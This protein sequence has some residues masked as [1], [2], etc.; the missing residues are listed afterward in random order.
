MLE[1]YDRAKMEKLKELRRLLREIMASDDPDAQMA[2]GEV[3]E[4][5]EEAE[6]GALE[7]PMGAGDEDMPVREATS[8]EMEEPEDAVEEDEITA[9]K[10]EYFKPKMAA[11]QPGRAGAKTVIVASEGMGAPRKPS[12]ATAIPAMPKK[13][14]GKLV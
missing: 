14:R 1:G 11:K 13:G 8:E 10:R 5:L 9:L 2:E 4:L 12:L 3:D 7:E 6:E